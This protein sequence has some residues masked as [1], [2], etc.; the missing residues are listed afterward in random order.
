MADKHTAVWEWIRSYPHFG[1]LHYNFG[2]A[3]DENETLIPMPGDRLVREDVLGNKWKHYDFAVMFFSDYDVAPESEGN[4]I[5]FAEM[6]RFID[7]VEEQNDAER[8]PEL[9]ERCV[10]ESVHSLQNIPQTAGAGEDTVQYM[11]QCRIAY[12]E[13]AH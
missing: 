3:G 5:D 10:V 11:V 8:F 4:R 6:Q 2:E 7:W 9:G 1:R 13:Y 12:M